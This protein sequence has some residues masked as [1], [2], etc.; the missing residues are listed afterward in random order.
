MVPVPTGVF[1]CEQSCPPW[2]GRHH[3]PST[4]TVSPV[5]VLRDVGLLARAVGNLNQWQ[6]AK[7]T[8]VKSGSDA[9]GARTHGLSDLTD[10][11]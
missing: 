2:H 5:T 11:M 6:R 3:S 10:R 7:P 8:I 9:A 1:A 4:C